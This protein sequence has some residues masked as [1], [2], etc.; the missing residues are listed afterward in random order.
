[1]TWPEAIVYSVAILVGVPAGLLVLAV[2]G[3]I[4]LVGC[5]WAYESVSWWWERRKKNG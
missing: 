4:A 1:M 3:A 2:V 5:V